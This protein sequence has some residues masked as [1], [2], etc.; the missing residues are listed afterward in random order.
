[1]LRIINNRSYYC[2]FSHLLARLETLLY[3]NCS[4]VPDRAV[5]SFS[6]ES[7]EVTLDAAVANNDAKT[8]SVI[9]FLKSHKV[10]S[11]LIRTGLMQTRPLYCRIVDNTPARSLVVIPESKSKCCGWTQYFS[12][13][14]TFWSFLAPNRAHTK[15]F[16]TAVVSK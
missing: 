5:L 1:L 8:K 10:E 7:R 6:I 15:H 3:C 14:T 16:S 9:D 12:Q 2:Y 13:I 11:R 4:V